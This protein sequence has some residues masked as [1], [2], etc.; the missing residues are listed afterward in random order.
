LLNFATKGPPDLS[1]LFV[2]G[3]EVL[4]D[5]PAGLA[6]RLAARCLLGPLAEVE[7]S[8]YIVGRLAA[9][10]ASSSLFSPDALITLHR[11]ALG[12][13]RR[14]NRI[15]DLA[16]LIAYARDLAAVDASVAAIAA[17]EFTKDLAA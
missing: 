10:G 6:D 13:P 8:A 7:S 2:G 12:L 14:L 4:L 9:A 1:L 16:L 11:A 5:L 17:R 15:A 3:A